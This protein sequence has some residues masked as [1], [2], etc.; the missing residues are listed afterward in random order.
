MA[1]EHTGGEPVQYRSSCDRQTLHYTRNERAAMCAT[2]W[3]SSSKR[4]NQTANFSHCC[5]VFPEDAVYQVGGNT[6]CLLL[7]TP[8]LYHYF[9]ACQSV[10][11]GVPLPSPQ[12]RLGGP[13]RRAPRPCA[14]CAWNSPADARWI[15]T[16]RGA[17]QTALPWLV[18][19]PS[20]YY[21]TP[22]FTFHVLSPSHNKPKK[23][24][25]G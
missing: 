18:Y 24:G 17:S 22:C 1:Q 3:G 25:P 2:M 4:R 6:R 8:I 7:N 9:S 19:A 12:L 15:P 5:S 21:R 14:R 23:S 13:P 10:G 16:G 11:A 20:S